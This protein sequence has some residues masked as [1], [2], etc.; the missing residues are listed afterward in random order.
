MG[1]DPWMIAACGAVVLL[2]VTAIGD[3]AEQ[4]GHYPAVGPMGIDV[5]GDLAYLTTGL[6]LLEIDVSNPTAPVVSR[7]IALSF[8][9]DVRVVGERAYVAD[10]NR[11]RIISLTSQMLSQVEVLVPRTTQT[12]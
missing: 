9:R 4:I 5:V 11:L 3:T 2:P 6:G 10:R 7:S 1:R 12:P 8:G